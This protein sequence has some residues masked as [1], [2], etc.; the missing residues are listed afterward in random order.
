M[1]RYA[2]TDDL[3][4]V[5]ET[6]YETSCWIWNGSRKSKWGHCSVSIGGK[7]FSAHRLLYEERVGPIPEGLELDHLCKNPACVRPDHLEPVIHA[8][9]IRRSPLAKLTWGEVNLIRSSPL[10]P[11]AL[12]EQLDISRKTVHD[13]RSGRSWVAK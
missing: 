9:N 7:E 3:W 4:S 1:R 13:I 2:I 8:E 10:G 12:S 11:K 6:D 5:V